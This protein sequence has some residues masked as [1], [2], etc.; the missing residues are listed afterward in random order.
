MTKSALDGI[1]GLGAARRKA[2]MRHFGSV[3]KIR[4]AIP[5]EIASVK[6]MPRSVAENVYSALHDTS[7]EEP[8]GA[9]RE[10]S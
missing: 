9:R 5:D 4:D 10:A 2:L 1:P 6:G 8:A 3:K 7:R